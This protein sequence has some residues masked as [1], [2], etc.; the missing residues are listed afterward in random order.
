MKLTWI[1]LLALAAIVAVSETPAQSGWFPVPTGSASILRALFCVSS[2]TVY[3]C[4]ADGIIAKTTNGGDTWSTTVLGGSSSFSDILFTRG[5]TGYVSGYNTQTLR[6]ELHRT[7]NGGAT[8]NLLKTGENN[9]SYVTLCFTDSSTGYIG[10]NVGTNGNIM[11][12][13]DAGSTWTPYSGTAYI[14]SI[15]FASATTGLAVGQG[16]VVYKT[17]NAGAT[18]VQKFQLPD[19]PLHDFYSVF[20]ADSA[21]AFAAGNHGYLFKSTDAGET[22]IS[23]YNNPG[24]T[25][26]LTSIW[27]TSPTAGF[28]VGDSGTI[29]K[30]TNRGGSWVQQPSTTN[31][32]L[33]SVSFVDQHVGY[34]AGSHGLVLKTTDGGTVSAEPKHPEIPSAYRLE[35]NYP[36]PFN[37]GTTITYVLPRSSEVRLTVCDV[38]GRTV[39]VLVNDTRGAG[40]H[41]VAFDASGLSSGVYLY[42]LQAGD[43]VQARKLMVLR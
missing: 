4:G 41:E 35:Q 43:F 12:T 7:T 10:M 19:A 38:L 29:M 24:F 8:W 22:W 13:T 26:R 11:T 32:Y 39:S 15:N 31:E 27:F 30:T 17:T 33:S 14:R 6:A 1:P 5:G 37:P 9:T 36:N 21:T 23:A 25:R 16:G 28:V 42:R 34:V 20:F 40:V 3:A 2:T 18:W